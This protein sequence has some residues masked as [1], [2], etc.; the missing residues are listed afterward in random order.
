MFQNVSAAV[1]GSANAAP[2]LG[3]LQ[4]RTVCDARTSRLKKVGFGT[5]LIVATV[6]I[7]LGFEALAGNFQAAKR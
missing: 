4:I 6:A 3:A 7:G 2:S 5:V 1:D